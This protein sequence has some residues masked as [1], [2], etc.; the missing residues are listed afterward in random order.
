MLSK[1]LD[2][3]VKYVDKKDIVIDVGC[4]H[5]LLDVYL[6]KEGI[7]DSIIVSDI[8]EGALKQGIDNI[9]K[10][11]LSKQIDARLGNGL[12]VIR[13]TDKVNTLL[14]SGMGTTT[15][16]DILNN[17]YIKHLDKLIIQ[18]NND[19]D[20]LR[21]EVV[22]L[23]YKIVAEEYLQDNFK[24]YINIIFEKGE[25]KYTK[26]E[27]RFGPFL[28]KD[29]EYLQF[30]LDKIAKIRTFIPTNKISLKFKLLKD[31]LKLKKY[32]KKA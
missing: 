21:K 31:E 10:N 4:D 25:A 1:R 13:I 28:L 26:D 3:L 32:L 29:K 5:A 11:K 15:I 19:H 16:L 18:S 30:E 2:S 23:G 14:I 24:N 20:E 7:L 12:E 17:E 8:H 6:V 22:K 9:K 27:L